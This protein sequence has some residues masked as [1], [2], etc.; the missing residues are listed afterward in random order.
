MYRGVKQ[1]YG[2]STG[3]SL[4]ALFVFL[5]LQA[6][7]ALFFFLGLAGGL[8]FLGLMAWRG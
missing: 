6:V 7:L 5:L 3:G 4:G 2:I 1:V 8:T